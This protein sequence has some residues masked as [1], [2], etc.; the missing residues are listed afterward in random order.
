LEFVGQMHK[1]WLGKTKDKEEPRKGE[2]M[3]LGLNYRGGPLSVDER[4]D[5]PDHVTRAGDRAP[6]APLLDASQAPLRLFDLFRGPHFTLLALGA[7]PLPS[8]GRRCAEAMRTY[9]IVRAGEGAPANDAVL[10]DQGGHAH[11]NYGEGLILI[12]P[13]GYLG[14]AGPCDGANGLNRYLGQFFG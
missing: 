12:R 9:R 1:D 6:D 8:L 2:H 10:V 4:H 3:Q 11:R 7:A 13:D 14:Y 5:V